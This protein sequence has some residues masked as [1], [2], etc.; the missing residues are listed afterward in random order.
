VPILQPMVVAFGLVCELTEIFSLTPANS[1]V[2]SKWENRYG[3]PTLARTG[4]TVLL[5]LSLANQPLPSGL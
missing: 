2:L 1:S 5:P 3:Q 4:L